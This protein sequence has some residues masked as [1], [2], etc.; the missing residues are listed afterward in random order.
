MTGAVLALVLAA[1]GNNE[2]GVASAPS[3]SATSVQSS[4]VTGSTVG[5]T[6]PTE[7]TT[8]TAE[9]TE[10]TEQSAASTEET[11]ESSESTDESTSTSEE[12]PPA[13]T[14]VDPLAADLISKMAAGNAGVTSV[15]GTVKTETGGTTIDITYKQQL[16][17]GKAVA[18][19]MNIPLGSEEMR[20]ILVDDKIYLSGV[21]AQQFGKKYVEISEDTRDENLKKIFATFEQSLE[22]TS[23]EQYAQFLAIVSEVKDEG[24]DTVNGEPAEK[25]TTKVDLTKLDES[26]LD[27]TVKASM[28]QLVSAGLTEFP[29]TI[30]LDSEGRTVQVSQD[31]EVMGQQAKT[32]VTM[33]GYNEPVKITAPNPKDVAQG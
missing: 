5:S 15:T 25:Y 4:V 23:T 21:L 14:G 28:Q 18:M 12:T 10:S 19:D 22:Q 17:D 9:L 27:S 32:L 2:A 24:S 29:M 8:S 3:T 31:F 30:W 13:S 26:T 16:K 6:E 33:S 11:T 20:F 1:C 7:P